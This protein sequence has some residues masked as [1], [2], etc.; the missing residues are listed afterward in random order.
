MIKLCI[1]ACASRASD[2]VINATDVGMAFNWLFEAE[3]A[4][5]DIF[6][7]LSSGGDSRAI[8][9]AYAFL[10]NEYAKRRDVVPEYML[11]QFLRNRVPSHNVMRVIDVM[12]RSRAIELVA[13]KDGAAYKPLKL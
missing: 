12:L 6:L 13:G 11:A 9:D 8:E 7:S 1:I 10:W 2:L 4:M 3:E 5:P